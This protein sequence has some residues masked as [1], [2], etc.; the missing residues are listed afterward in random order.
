V[1]GY[2]AALSASA[3]SFVSMVQRFGPFMNPGGAAVSLT[4][5][6]S[7]KIIPGMWA[8]CSYNQVQR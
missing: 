5:L 8:M 7:E 6:A 4:Y 2:L 1:Q 3:Y